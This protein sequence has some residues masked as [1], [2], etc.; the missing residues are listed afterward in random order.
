MTSPVYGVEHT[1][2]PQEVGEYDG[3]LKKWEN[4]TEI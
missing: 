1:V 3:D 2:A 4:T